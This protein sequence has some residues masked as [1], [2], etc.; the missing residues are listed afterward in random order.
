[1][2]ASGDTDK[3]ACVAGSQCEVNVG[4]LRIL[5]VVSRPLARLVPVE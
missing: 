4:P 3:N 2:G 1:M 5:V